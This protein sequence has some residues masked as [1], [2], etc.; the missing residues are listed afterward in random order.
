M[1][2]RLSVLR[3]TEP[4]YVKR[5]L[6]MYEKRPAKRRVHTHTHQVRTVRIV[7]LRRHWKETLKRDLHM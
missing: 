7:V 4:T 5:G 3:S 2:R 6:Y 1:L